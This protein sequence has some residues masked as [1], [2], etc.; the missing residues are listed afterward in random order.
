[1]TP[2]L[3]D[4]RILIILVILLFP[5]LFRPRIYGFDPVGYFSWVR[6]VII[7]GDLNTTNEYLAYGNE[8]VT[9]PTKTGYNHNPYAI[10]APLLWSPFFL[11]AHGIETGH[12]TITNAQPPTGYETIYVVFVSIGSVLYGFAGVIILYHLAQGYSDEHVARW[13]TLGGWLATPLVFYMYSHPTMSHAVDAF[14]NTLVVL[15]WINA[16]SLTSKRWF[17]L[18]AA[19]G[20]AMLVRT[21]NFLLIIIP[22]FELIYRLWQS[23]RTQRTASASSTKNNQLS[24]K[25]ILLSATSYGLGGLVTFWPQLLTWRIV[26]GQWI[27]ANPYAYYDQHFT[28]GRLW[29]M[30][31]LFSTNRGLFTWSPILIFAV[32]GLIPL[33]RRNKRLTIFLGCSLMSQVSL[34]SMWTMPSGALAFGARLLINNMPAYILGLA[35]FSEWIKGRGVT[36]RAMTLGVSAFIVWNF[37]LIAQYATETIP[38][39]GEFPISDMIIGQFRVL[40]TQFNRIVQAVLTR[41]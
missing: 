18:G 17:L 9:G 29:I 2:F 36:K 37:L 8:D 3:R 32:L 1:M 34:V 27:V 24:T 39:S 33:F 22:A 26:Y 7:D 30:P 10:G 38:R 21:Q 11:L 35:A 4:H 40:P 5:L 19:T 41:R 31:I 20:L 14:A 15:A 6:S 23:I 13:A 28:W 16:R 25:Q 12:A